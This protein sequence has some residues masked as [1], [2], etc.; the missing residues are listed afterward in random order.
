MKRFLA[1][2][3]SVAILFL[4]SCSI[5]NEIE[6]DSDEKIVYELIPEIL[7]DFGCGLGYGDPVFP[8]FESDN[9]VITDLETTQKESADTYKMFYVDGIVTITLSK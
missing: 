4:S 3:I 9:M 1:F 2:A 7:E 5:T 6:R 8:E